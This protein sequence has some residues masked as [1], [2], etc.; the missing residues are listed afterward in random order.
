MPVEPETI[1]YEKRSSQY[2]AGIISGFGYIPVEGLERRCFN[3]RCHLNHRAVGINI[4][5][6]PAGFLCGFKL[7]SIVG[8][9]EYFKDRTIIRNE[10]PK[11]RMRV[12]G[13]GNCQELKEL[14]KELGNTF[15]VSVLVDKVSEKPGKWCC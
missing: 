15:E 6:E 11:W 2:I 4:L 1:V 14:A 10:T 8:F 7:P 3:G 9:L 5:L 12:Y 13:R